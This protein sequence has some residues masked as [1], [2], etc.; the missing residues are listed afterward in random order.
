[1]QKKI[2]GFVDQF[3][4]WRNHNVRLTVLPKLT[5]LTFSK[6]QERNTRLLNHDDI[7]YLRGHISSHLRMGL[8]LSKDTTFGKMWFAKNKLLGAANRNYFLQVSLLAN[9]GDEE[10]ER[11]QERR[12]RPE[13]GGCIIVRRGVQGMKA[14]Y[15]WPLKDRLVI[16]RSNG[17]ALADKWCFLLG[18]RSS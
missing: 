8:E 7:S 2:F 13:K 18:L 1:M 17:L 14:G 11:T 15:R 6:S 3:R 12:D 4:N 9:W 5:R 10:G 16:L